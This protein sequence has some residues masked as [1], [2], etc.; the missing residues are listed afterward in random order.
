MNRI[1]RLLHKMNFLTRQRLAVKYSNKYIISDKDTE[2][3]K[4]LDLKGNDPNT[5]IKKV[6]EGFD[7]VNN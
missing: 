6:L 5:E 2:R 4:P 7:P 1:S 3:E